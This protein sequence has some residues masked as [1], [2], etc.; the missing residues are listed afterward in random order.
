MGAIVSTFFFILL[1]MFVS[2]EYDGLFFSADFTVNLF[3][4]YAQFGS[5]REHYLKFCGCLDSRMQR[6]ATKKAQKNIMRKMGSIHVTEMSG[7][8]SVNSTDS[9]HT[10]LEVT[11]AVDS[12]MSASSPS[13][14]SP[15]VA[16]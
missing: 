2:N 5:A 1:T 3:C 9:H 6:A 10:E 11:P 8:N 12:E 14:V 4:I 15:S 13:A 7:V 16:S